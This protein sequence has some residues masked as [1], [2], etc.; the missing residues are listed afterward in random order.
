MTD[1]QDQIPVMAIRLRKTE[2][3]TVV[4]V[5]I[6]GSWIEVIRERSDG[7]FCHIVEASGI[8]SLYY[9]PPNEQLKIFP[10]ITRTLS[11]TP[12]M[13]IGYSPSGTLSGTPGLSGFSLKP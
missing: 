4:D 3:H 2:Q 1:T 10:S 6:G 8:Y 13:V 5:E 9:A 7:E 11:R 12:S